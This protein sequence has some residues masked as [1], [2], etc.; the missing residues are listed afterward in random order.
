MKN[1]RDGKSY[2]TNLAFTPPEYLRTG[3]VIPESVVYSFGTLLLD[4]LSGK[5]IPPSHVSAPNMAQ[6][7]LGGS[8]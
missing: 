4:L 1:S 3:R 7:L 2:S 8:S 5:H 6:L